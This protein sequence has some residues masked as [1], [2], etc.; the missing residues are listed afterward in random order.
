MKCR[1]CGAEI[2]FIRTRAGKY[3]PCEAEAVYYNPSPAE[4]NIFIDEDGSVT[5]GKIA[6]RDT[7]GARRGYIPHWASCP[8]ANRFRRKRK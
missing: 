8:G 6:E 7:S 3:M 1:D 2:V 4:D 5:W